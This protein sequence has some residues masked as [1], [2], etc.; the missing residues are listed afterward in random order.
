MEKTVA[1]NLLN[2]YDEKIAGAAVFAKNLLNEWFR[3]RAE[4]PSIVIYHADC[5]D[6][7]RVFALPDFDRVVYKKVKAN[8]FWLRILYEQLVMPFLIRD[9]KVYFSPTPV[10][11]FLSKLFNRR[12]KHVITIHDMIP[13]FVPKKY[14]KI[15][16]LYVKLISKY[17]SKYADRIITVS[18]NSRNDISL[19]AKINPAKVIVI[20]NFMPSLVLNA[21]ISYDQFFVS[22]STI[23]PG[24]NIENTIRG[25]KVFLE[26]EAH[27]KYKFYWVGKIGWGYSPAGLK[28]MIEA[29][30]LEKNFFLL[31]YI[32]ESKKTELLSHCTAIVYLS[33]YEGFGLP[34]LEG[35]YYGK[36]A[37]VSDSSSLPEVIGKAGILC[38][39]GDPADIADALTRICENLQSYLNEIPKQLEKFDAHTQ[40]EKFLK[41]MAD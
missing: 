18:E 40:V 36:P 2:F 19:I 8:N 28:A 14:G 6:I 10:M 23:E 20:Y 34:V 26:N 5:L 12:L 25:F 22:I 17:G 35:L 3:N 38:D 9:F 41:V 13:F 4:L 27:R 7:K 24:K 31:G 37:V 33:H 29:S 11:P 15:R 39:K 21:S 32:D 1:I 16:S 30:G